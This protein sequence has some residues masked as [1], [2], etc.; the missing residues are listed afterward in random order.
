MGPP[1]DLLRLVSAAISAARRA[2]TAN[3][4]R[5]RGRS[6]FAKSH[7][8]GALREPESMPIKGLL[9]RCPLGEAPA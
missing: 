8:A 4:T 9:R 3:R 7:V 5:Q 2:D 1:A 6:L